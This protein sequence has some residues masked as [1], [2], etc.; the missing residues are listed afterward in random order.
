[1]D[2]PV[3]RLLDLPL[4]QGMERGRLVPLGKSAEPFRQ[5]AGDIL[6]RQFHPANQFS[7]IVKGVVEHSIGGDGEAWAMDQ[8][9]WPWAALGWSGFL[10]PCRHGTTATAVSR[11]ELVRW[12]HEE[13][14]R[15]FYADP[16]LAV[17]F[18]RL[19]LDSVRRQFEWV[20][21]E[22]LAACPSA[23][24]RDDPP[25]VGDLGGEKP[26]FG[27]AFALM[28]R[29]S[30]FQRFGDK[31]LERVARASRVL[32]VPCGSTLVDQ[33]EV[34]SGI[35]LLDTG[36][37]VAYFSQRNELGERLHRFRSIPPDGGILAGVP[38]RDADYV[39]EAKVVSTSDCRLYV[40]PAAAIET[41]ISDDPEFGRSFVQRQLAR[42]S[43]LISLARLVKP[44]LDHKT[45][46]GAIEA[47]LE[48]NQARISVTS[49]LHTVPHLLKSGLTVGDA[50]TTL[51]T[52]RREG[53][54]RE[55][56]IANWCTDIL[57]GVRAEAIFYRKVLKAYSMITSAPEERTTAEL[58]GSCDEHIAD[59]FRHLKTG[60]YGLG[61][62]P[63]ASGHVVIMNHLACPA[64]YEFPNHYHFSFDT[65]FVSALLHEVYGTSPLRIVRQSPGAEH[66]HNLFYGRLGHVM[67]PTV[68][69]D[70]EESRQSSLEELRRKATQ[71]LFDAGLV[72]LGRGENVLVCPE[73]MAQEATDSP[74]R[75]HG[76]AFRLALNANPEP[77]IVPIAIAGFERR[78][79][80]SRLVA[81]IQ[82]P[83]RLSERLPDHNFERLRRFLDDFRRE[84]AEAVKAAQHLSR[85]ADTSVPVAFDTLPAFAA[86]HCAGTVL[87][88]EANQK[89]KDDLLGKR[90]GAPAIRA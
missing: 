90:M 80:D 33:D 10:P 22:R 36:K 15:I 3:T 18:F 34:I 76:G 30:F 32:N 40:I 56:M 13:L 62:L 4:W 60:L 50:F 24:I 71:T 66:G 28:R 2:S 83:F 88:R 1:M 87:H 23:P 86:R 81:V 85:T 21:S 19:V 63:S 12:Q 9:S 70:I 48:Q 31:T 16:L 67:V 82:K 46:T 42:L 26:A 58:R 45:E 43:Q 49:A 57:A 64:Y 14:A 61:N 7:L 59:A 78:Y 27:R 89:I 29:S 8:I 68:E 74:A 73:G 37:A 35:L 38:T 51:D 47:V 72:A 77:F 6:F 65:A 11:I 84:F 54:Y 75:F 53:S 52:L 17:T 41:I 69:S 20:R 79:K 25:H 39:A 55:R 5:S 44:N